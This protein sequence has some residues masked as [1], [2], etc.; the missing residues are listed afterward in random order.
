MKALCAST[1]MNSEKYYYNFKM[2]FTIFRK[3]RRQPRIQM[4]YMIHM[5]TVGQKNHRHVS[6]TQ[7][8]FKCIKFMQQDRLTVLNN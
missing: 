6:S 4:T 8:G 3:M 5:T 1:D 2:N 7:M